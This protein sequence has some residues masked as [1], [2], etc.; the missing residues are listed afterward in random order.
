ML[1][2]YRNEYHRMS[3]H[4]LLDFNFETKFCD[5]INIFFIHE[6]LFWRVLVNFLNKISRLFWLCMKRVFIHNHKKVLHI[7]RVTITYNYKWEYIYI[8][9]CIKLYYVQLYN[10]FTTFKYTECIMECV[11]YQI[12]QICIINK[13]RIY[14]T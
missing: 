8:S 10:L 7:F 5:N 2:F 14:N 9:W 6:W 13:C 3:V 11:L 4:F 1:N 12:L